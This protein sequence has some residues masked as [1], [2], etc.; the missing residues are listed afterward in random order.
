MHRSH[1]RSSRKLDGRKAV[2]TILK[3]YTMSQKFLFIAILGMLLITCRKSQT[4]QPPIDDAR[5]YFNVSVLPGIPRPNPNNY[6][7]SPPRSVRWDLAAVV[8]TPTG[9]Q[10]ITA[11]VQFKDKIYLTSD[12]SGHSLFDLSNITQLLI[13][14]DSGNSYHYAQLT[15]I[16]D[17]NYKTGSP[18]P[19]GLCLWED[20]AGNSLAKPQRIRPFSAPATPATRTPAAST[21]SAG[22]PVTGTPAAAYTQSIRVCN[23]IYGYNYSPD[24]PAGGITNWSE[25]SCTTYSFNQETVGPGIF[26][27]SGI[28][29]IRPIIPLSL[30]VYPP[31]N[32][33]A[34][35]TDYFKCF[36]NGATPDHTY[37][38][39]L[40]VDQPDPG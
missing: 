5:A 2:K 12:L 36:T 8:S 22:T 13:Y 32:P 38:V 33:I 28:V 11:P 10:L 19:S 31:T 7:A 37:T 34:N 29:N 1:Q 40:C 14:R 24:D 15:F 23:D 6:R 4:N 27:P 39:Q 26:N 16:P 18:A 30:V 9:G 20:W 21:P 35:I 3:P 25:T 17:S